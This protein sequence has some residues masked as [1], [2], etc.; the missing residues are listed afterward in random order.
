MRKYK[1]S[2]TLMQISLISKQEF[3]KATHFQSLLFIIILDYFLRNSGDKH[4][5][6][7]SLCQKDC[8]GGNPTKNRL[9]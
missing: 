4:P 6:L 8:Q 1:I 2:I 3:C 7:V 9:M 5:N